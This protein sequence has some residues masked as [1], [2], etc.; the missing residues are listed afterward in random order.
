MWPQRRPPPTCHAPR[1]QPSFCFLLG[2]LDSEFS[3]AAILAKYEESLRLLLPGSVSSP[4]SIQPSSE[5]AQRTAEWGDGDLRLGSIQTGGDGD[6][7]DGESW[8]RRFPGGVTSPGLTQPWPEGVESMVKVGE[9]L[10]LYDEGWSVKGSSA[11]GGWRT[12]LEQRRFRAEEWAATN[13]SGFGSWDD[14]SRRDC[15]RNAV[16]EAVISKAKRIT[17]DILRG[18]QRPLWA[19]KLTNR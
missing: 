1:I 7:D 5:E 8:R 12:G 17:G 6:V 13:G 18:S 16:V 9:G 10:E 11:K 3:S 14:E 15:W 19:R 2:D 4:G